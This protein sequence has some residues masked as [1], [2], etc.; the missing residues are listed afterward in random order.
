MD[1]YKKDLIRQASYN[2][3][4]KR[5]SYSGKAIYGEG[6]TEGGMTW[7]NFTPNPPGNL[8]AYFINF[9]SKIFAKPTTKL[10]TNVLEIGPGAGFFTRF[11]VEKF[12][13]SCYT[14]VDVSEYFCIELSK[15]FKNINQDH[16]IL[17]GDALEH[18]LKMKDG[19]FDAIFICSTLHHLPDREELFLQLSRIL[20]DGGIILI[21]EPTHYIPRILT[22][23][24]K[25]LKRSYLSDQS[26]SN[27]SFLSIHHYCT[28]GELRNLCDSTPGLRIKDI[29]FQGGKKLWLNR[30][31]G[32]YSSAQLYCLITKNT[33]NFYA[34]IKDA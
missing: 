4:N 11:F 17:C 28:E 25:I 32:K 12:T 30:L 13:P 33:S 18:T 29:A 31:L 5:D 3:N 20:K 1:S 2:Y 16:E 7:D 23:A 19:Y 15:K 10:D 6:R 34:K 9:T 27:P 21:T 14:A 8:D 24:K 22:L 26:F